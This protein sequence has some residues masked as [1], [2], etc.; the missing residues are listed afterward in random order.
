[1]G[2]RE[3]P[4]SVWD[5]RLRRAGELAALWPFAREVLGFFRA[6][7]E[8]QRDLGARFPAPLPADAGFL[9]PFLPS[10]FD[11][12]ERQG[13][14]E[15]AARARVWRGR[16]REE[17]ERALRSFWRGE[18]GEPAEQFFP[19]AVLQPFARELG[20]RWRRE[21]SASRA[22]V[23]AGACPFCGHPPALSVLR[24]DQEAAA[25]GRSLF[26]SLCSLEWSFARVL[27]AGCR[28]ERPEKLPRYAAEEIPWVRVEACDTCRRYLKA[29][30]LTKGP[31]AE[32][33]VDD[34]A[35]VPLD[36]L[37]REQGYAK[38]APN[39]AGI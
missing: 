35:S 13:P 17:W 16:P 9:A 28:E 7:T 6:L 38:L 31:D 32:P 19:K 14:A 25:V 33:V 26:C 23:P 30:D 10:L 18:E 20:E 5:R 8:F 39:L 11:L 12:V 24:E 21:E 37:A 29:V 15:L 2:R 1:M 27:C 34:L 36:V 22:G 3:A 4:L